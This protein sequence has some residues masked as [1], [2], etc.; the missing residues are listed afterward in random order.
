MLEYLWAYEY[1]IVSGASSY[2]L[3]KSVKWNVI[4]P[5]VKRREDRGGAANQ[6]LDDVLMKPGREEVGISSKP[7]CHIP[8]LF[9]PMM[10]RLR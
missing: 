10:D 4:R 8:V 9:N 6:G 3:H 1:L 5:L 2:I 7:V